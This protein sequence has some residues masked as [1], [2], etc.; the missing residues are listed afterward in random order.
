MYAL[1]DAMCNTRVSVYYL[2]IYIN[3]SFFNTFFYIFSHS[4]ICTCYELVYIPATGDNFLMTHQRD[5]HC[6]RREY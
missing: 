6:K 5:F 2:N 4:Y 3:F 1:C